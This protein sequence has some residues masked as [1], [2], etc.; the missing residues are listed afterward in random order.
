MS[1]I[2]IFH[3]NRCSN[4]RGAL[5]LLRDRGLEPNIVD[6]IAT[7]LTAAELS[8]L[9]MHV[10]VPVRELLRTKEEAYKALGL[11]N[12][13]V[14]DAQILMAVA[15]HPVLLNRPIVVTPKGAALCRPPEKV[16]ELL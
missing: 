13:A 9:V 6:Y 15:Q 10:G 3:N 4:S 12:P 14:S 7:P 1:D 11:D 5:Q 16:L 2:T 8:E